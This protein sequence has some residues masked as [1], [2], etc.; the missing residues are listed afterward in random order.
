MDVAK[1]NP[2]VESWDRRGEILMYQSQSRMLNHGIGGQRERERE[3]GKK[4]QGYNTEF[5]VHVNK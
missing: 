5:K 2:E 4:G 3:R 1:S